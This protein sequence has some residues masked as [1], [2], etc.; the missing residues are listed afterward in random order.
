MGGGGQVALSLPPPPTR[1][2]LYSMRLPLQRASCLPTQKLIGREGGRRGERVAATVGNLCDA[3]ALLCRMV[4]KGFEKALLHKE[5]QL[6]SHSFAK[7]L[8]SR[9][10]RIEPLTV[11][12]II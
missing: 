8:T 5:P 6:N 1:F 11:E 4:L 2:R 3:G 9:T 7:R 12:S 10:E